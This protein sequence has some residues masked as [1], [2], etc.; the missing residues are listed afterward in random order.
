M[1]LIKQLY[2]CIFFCLSH[3]ISPAVVNNFIIGVILHFSYFDILLLSIHLPYDLQ[4]MDPLENYRQLISIVKVL[5]KKN[6]MLIIY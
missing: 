1:H 2:I 5:I 4:T 6:I 3:L